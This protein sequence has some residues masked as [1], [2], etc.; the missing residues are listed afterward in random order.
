[1]LRNSKENN[2]VTEDERR[3]GGGTFLIG[4]K[5]EDLKIN[6]MIEK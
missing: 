3:R 6:E 2:R 4:R 5:L 1:L